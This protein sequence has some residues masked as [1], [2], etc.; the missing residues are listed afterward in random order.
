MNQTSLHTERVKL[1]NYNNATIEDIEKHIKSICISE[2]KELTPRVD[3]WSSQLEFAIKKISE[4]LEF[5]L[6]KC[7]NYFSFYKILKKHY[8]Y[9]RALDKK[10]LNFQMP[11]TCKDYVSFLISQ[12]DNLKLA[13]AQSDKQTTIDILLEDV[14]LSNLIKKCNLYMATNGQKMSLQESNR[15]HDEQVESMK[16]YVSLLIQKKDFISK[17]IKVEKD[18]IKLIDLK[19]ELFEVKNKITAT[20]RY[21][22]AYDNRRAKNV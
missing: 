15:I 21:I 4:I 20:N 7:E 1:F 18:D 17:N 2:T 14:N 6:I 8:Y 9:N 11:Y 22:K 16:E 3:F 5:E 10:T 13:L 19:I 12:K